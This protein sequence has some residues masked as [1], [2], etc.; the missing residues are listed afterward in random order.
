MKRQAAGKALLEC[1]R[2]GSGSKATEARAFGAFSEED[3]LEIVREAVRHEIAPIVFQTL[4]EITLP[5]AA[6]QQLQECALSNARRNLRLYQTLSAVLAALRD[7]DI[8][9]IV[10]KGAHLAQNIYRDIAARPMT[11]IDLMLQESDLSRAYARLSSLGYSRLER[12]HVKPEHYSP[13]PHGNPLVSQERIPIELHWTI[14]TGPFHIDVDGLWQRAQAMSI[15]GVEVLVLA[16]EDLVLHL[17][18]HAAF[19]HHFDQGLRP[20]WDIVKVLERH[21]SDIDWREVQ[22]RA[23][24]WGIRKHVH[25]AL[26]LAN[27]LL[28]AAVAESVLTALKPSDFDSRLAELATREIL[29][30]ESMS[31]TFARM[32]GD[33]TL[34]TKASLALRS[35]FPPRRQLATLYDRY[36]G[37][38]AVYSYYPVRWG[39]LIRTYV[40]P[41]WRWLRGENAQIAAVQRGRERAAFL[42]WLDAADHGLG[43]APVDGSR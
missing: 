31:P 13:L 30:D 19:H 4:H 39:D 28:G 8:R 29:G 36:A 40:R 2:L 9:V 32:F 37:P 11:D 17:C 41:T 3:W 10:L 14:E 33:T 21:G 6:R 23:V 43:P 27:A 38:Y 16:P 7:A 25:L 34:L 22:H 35:A 42:D 18:V 24:E 15:A 1:L 5:V 20:L 12:P 26:F